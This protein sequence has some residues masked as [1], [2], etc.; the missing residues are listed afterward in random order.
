[1]T[2]SGSRK[3]LRCNKAAQPRSASG[4][5]LPVRPC[6]HSVSSTP[7]N[8]KFPLDQSLTVECQKP[9]NAVQQGTC[10]ESS[11]DYLVGAC[12]KRSWYLQAKQLRRLQIY[13][14]VEL[15]RLF[16]WKIARLRPTQNFVDVV[17]GASEL[18]RKV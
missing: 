5:G 13:H 16:N 8:R 9:T 15:G 4:Q 7:S 18:I 12:E 10:A 3:P 1:M 2:Q 14:Q 6:D 17:S 11:F